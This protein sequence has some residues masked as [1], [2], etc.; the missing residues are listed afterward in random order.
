VPNFPVG[1]LLCYTAVM[2]RHIQK[3]MTQVYKTNYWKDQ[4]SRSGSGSNTTNTQF[5]EKEFPPIVNDLN[6]NSIL[7]IPCGDFAW[8]PRLLKNLPEH[9][10]YHGADIVEP[11]IAINKQYSN[12]RISFSC[13]DIT[14]DE[15]PYAD[16]VFTRDCLNHLPQE[17]IFQALNNIKL[18]GIKYIAVTHFNWRTATNH[19]IDNTGRVK[20]RKL[21]LRLEPFNFGP[22]LDFIVEGSSEPLGKDK[23]IGIWK[24]SD[25]PL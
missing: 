14:S 17:K 10:T 11:M 23:M 6:I 7:D 21:N 4:E 3:A 22:P 20:W 15:L 8:M 12:D 24:V 1:G 16:I 19:D 5:I 18:S 25:L 9:V 13:L 2:D